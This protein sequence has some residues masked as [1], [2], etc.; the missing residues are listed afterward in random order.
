MKTISMTTLMM[1]AATMSAQADVF[2]VAKHDAAHPSGWGYYIGQTFTLQDQGLHG[3]GSIPADLS[4]AYLH[5]FKVFPWAADR[6]PE[7]LPETAYVYPAA[8][9]P[10]DSDFAEVGMFSLGMGTHVGEGVYAFDAIELDVAESYA[11]VLSEAA[12]ILYW[13]S[14]PYDG[15]EAYWT[16][17]ST[18]GTSHTIEAF[19]T[20]IDFRAVLST[21]GVVPEPALASLMGLGLLAIARR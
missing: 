4:T 10:L 13:N 16:N 7:P 3:T 17:G 20:D 19:H 12:G 5:S 2:T 11:F 6:N 14:S 8:L 15:G 21:D 9:M 18:R 1:L